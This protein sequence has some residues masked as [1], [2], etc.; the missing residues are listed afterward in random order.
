MLEYLADGLAVIGTLLLIAGVFLQ[1]GLG[2]S[3]II[4]GIAVGAFGVNLARILNA[5]NS[6]EKPTA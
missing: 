6:A 3:L 2:W 4:A 1:F 5:A